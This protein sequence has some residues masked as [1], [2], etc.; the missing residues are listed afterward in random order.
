[1]IGD[2]TYRFGS[3]AYRN[4]LKERQQDLGPDACNRLCIGRAHS[5]MMFIPLSQMTVSA[6]RGQLA[7]VAASFQRRSSRFHFATFE[8]RRG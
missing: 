8:N 3:S 7:R 5:R 2:K 4:L 6:D 1:M